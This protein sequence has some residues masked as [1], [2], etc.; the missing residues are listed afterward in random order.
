MTDNFLEPIIE[1]RDD[2]ILNNLNNIEERIDEILNN[3]DDRTDEILN[4]INQQNVEIQNKIDI[5]TNCLLILVAGVTSGLIFDI[6][7]NNK[8]E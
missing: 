5:L 6:F 1:E 2:K 7:F 4:R 3:I 8:S